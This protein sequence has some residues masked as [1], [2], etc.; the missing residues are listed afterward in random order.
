MEFNLIIEKGEDDYLLAEVV[1]LPGCHT[2][3]KTMDELINRIKE[4]ISL[5]LELQE[6]VEPKSNFIGTQKIEV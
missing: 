6:T 2:Q 1:E 4:A 5:Y 3:A